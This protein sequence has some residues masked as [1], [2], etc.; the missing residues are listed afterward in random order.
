MAMPDLNKR[1]VWEKHNALEQRAEMTDEKGDLIIVTVKTVKVRSTTR[2][3]TGDKEY[4]ILT[5]RLGQRQIKQA[6]FPTF[7]K[8][9]SAVEGLAE[10][11]VDA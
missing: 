11:L 8:A 6:E 2:P 10:A 1:V 7:K 9:T 3:K 5:Q 4:H